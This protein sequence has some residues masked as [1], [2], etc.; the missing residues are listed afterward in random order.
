MYYATPP[1]G[2]TVFYDSVNAGF[3]TLQGSLDDEYWFQVYQGKFDLALYKNFRLRY[4]YL[5]LQDYGINKEIHRIEPTLRLTRNLYCHFLY[6]PTFSKKLDE[7]GL[8]LS[9]FYNNLNYVEGFF[10]IRDF[11]N[12]LSQRAV[13]PD[14]SRDLYQKQPLGL[15][16]EARRNF[17]SGFVK[18]Y[19]E[20]V[21]PSTKKFETSGADS[22]IYYSSFFTTSRFELRPFSFFGLGGT[23]SYNHFGK[24]TE[25]PQL[26]PLTDSL[27]DLT[28]EPYTFFPLSPKLR[29][30]LRFRYNHKLHNDYERHWFAPGLLFEYQPN[31]KTVYSFGYQHSWRNRWSADT[32][33][34]TNYDTNN[35]LDLFF[36]Y[37]FNHRGSI[38]IK[39]GIDLDNLFYH[40][41]GY[42][43]HDPHDM[44]Y[45]GLVLGF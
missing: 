1:S 10:G 11:E 16:L 15:S 17:K 32:A 39:E 26:S 13:P 7:I 3:L 34:V 20:Y 37:I 29:F 40:N 2:W 35:R 5:R 25:Y 38:V 31:P 18:I 33:L 21:T 14:R 36:E 23:V 24:L 9:L 44:W 42:F 19:G 4:R 43:L 41:L 28:I 27:S 30:N 6:I 8:G 45:W 12:N 22:L